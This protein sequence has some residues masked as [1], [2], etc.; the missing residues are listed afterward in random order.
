MTIKSDG[1][2]SDKEYSLA[3]GIKADDRKAHEK[4]RLSKLQSIL[5]K[6]QPTPTL[7]IKEASTSHAASVQESNGKTGAVSR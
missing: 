2:E 7:G 4:E 1:Y 3:V 5:A 6:K